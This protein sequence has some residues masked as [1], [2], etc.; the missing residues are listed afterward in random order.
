[1]GIH[2]APSRPA[3]PGKTIMLNPSYLPV[4]TLVSIKYL[5]KIYSP[6]F[7]SHVHSFTLQEVTIIATIRT[8]FIT[9]YDDLTQRSRL[10][11]IHLNLIASSEGLYFNTNN[12]MCIIDP[13]EITDCKI[14]SVEDLPLY[15]GWKHTWPLLSQMLRGEPSC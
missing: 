11:G 10:P 9:V 13:K 8:N 15:I 6:L 2:L 12:L 1:M 3:A 14:V 4:N 7:S 5:H